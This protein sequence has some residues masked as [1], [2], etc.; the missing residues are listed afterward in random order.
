MIPTIIMFNGGNTKYT[1]WYKN[2]YP[3]INPIETTNLINSLEKLGNVVL[4]DPIFYFDSNDINKFASTSDKYMFKI[5]DLDIFSHC[6]KLYE[7]IYEKLYEKICKK[8]NLEKK[9]ILI[10]HSRGYLIATIF[11]YMYSNQVVGYINLDGGLNS[12]DIIKHLSELPDYS[13]I[14]NDDLKKI[15]YELKKENSSNNRNKLADIVKYF[16]Y[17]QYLKIDYKFDSIPVYAFNNIYNDNQINLTMPDYVEKTL[18]PKINYNNELSKSNPNVSSIYY[19]G[20]THWFYFGKES[21]IIDAVK[22]IL[23]WVLSK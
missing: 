8:N 14:T 19:V 2:P 9:F 6:K 5:R 23:G 22:K 10:S 20:L 21:D 17:S 12:S 13:N 16:M 15:F 7:K 11:A 3:S 1:Q 18:N 4:Y